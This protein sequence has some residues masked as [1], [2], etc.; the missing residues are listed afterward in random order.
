[1]ENV[2]HNRDLSLIGRQ[3]MNLVKAKAILLI[4]YGIVKME[5]GAA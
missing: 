5:F 2:K 3:G 1:M 4:K